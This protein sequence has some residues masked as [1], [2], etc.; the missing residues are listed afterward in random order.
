MNDEISNEQSRDKLVLHK[1]EIMYQSPRVRSA[2]NYGYFLRVICIYDFL[3]FVS[4]YYARKAFNYEIDKANIPM[5]TED[6]FS[7]DDGLKLIQ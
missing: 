3:V 5:E 6:L 2:R 7:D 4:W 1:V